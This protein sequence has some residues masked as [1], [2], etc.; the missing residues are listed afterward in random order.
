MAKRRDEQAELQALRAKV[1]RLEADVARLT[2]EVVLGRLEVEEVRKQWD[3][4]RERLCRREEDRK[5]RDRNR[6]KGVSEPREGKPVG[7]ALSERDERIVLS[8]EAKCADW[9][10]GQGGNMGKVETVRIKAPGGFVTINKSDFDPG[11]HELVKPEP[12]KP[13]KT[14]QPVGAKE[15]MSRK[16]AWQAVAKEEHMTESAVRRV[17]ERAKAKR[18]T[19]EKLPSNR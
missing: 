13:A 8:Y 14:E 9:P 18:L 4:D 17:L 1:A 11:R 2:A 19:Y 12:P 5:A 6:K 16:E 15:G 7:P 3:K 10:V